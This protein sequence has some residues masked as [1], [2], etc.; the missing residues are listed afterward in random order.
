MS[1]SH[2]YVHIETVI[3]IEVVGEFKLSRWLKLHDATGERSRKD[4]DKL[5]AYIYDLEYMSYFIL[6]LKQL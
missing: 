3:I 6:V 2:T 4:T 1:G 5:Y